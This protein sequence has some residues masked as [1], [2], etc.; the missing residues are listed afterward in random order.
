MKVQIEWLN[1][2]VEEI[3]YKGD[4][5]RILSRLD[6]NP[7][8]LPIEQEFGFRVINM[9]HVKEIKLYREEED[10]ETKTENSECV[11]NES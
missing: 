1:G 7:N 4:I 8:E 2:T 3:Q 11:N 5:F 9:D 10:K 6:T